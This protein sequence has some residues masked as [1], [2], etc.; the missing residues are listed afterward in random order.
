M[1]FLR[2]GARMLSCLPGLALLG[3]MTAGHAQDRA[4]LAVSAT[5]V[6]RCAVDSVNPNG[7]MDPR[8]ALRA[9][10]VT[11]AATTPYEVS[12]APTTQAAAPSTNWT[13]Y[14]DGTILVTVVY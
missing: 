2:Y 12:A 9:T 14:P 11:C 8:A 13:A 1:P 10:R 3:W 7:R 5:V 4:A 6:S